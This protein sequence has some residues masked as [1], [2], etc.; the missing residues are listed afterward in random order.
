MVLEIDI[1]RQAQEEVLKKLDELSSSTA[2]S[3]LKRAINDVGKRAE[4]TMLENA[5]QRYVR[6][7]FIGLKEG[8]TTKQ[9]YLNKLSYEINSKNKSKEIIDFNV[10]PKRLASSYKRPPKNISAQVIKG[11]GFRTLK[12]YGMKAFVAAFDSGHIAAVVRVPGEEYTQAKYR[13]PREEK[14][15]DLTKIVPIFS[16]SVPSMLGKTYSLMEEVTVKELNDT[17]QQ[18]IA[19]VI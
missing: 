2:K 9:A 15:W 1:S 7:K 6:Q 3:V 11:K 18:Y 14:G 10:K 4:R 5:K 19:E 16:A 8:L 12:K 17:L 13:K